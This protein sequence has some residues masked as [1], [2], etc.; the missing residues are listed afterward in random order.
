MGCTISGPIF[1]PM[2]SGLLRWAFPEKNT[3][4]N[5]S[6]RKSDFIN[7]NYIAKILRSLL[8]NLYLANYKRMK[9][10]FLS[11]KIIGRLNKNTYTRALTTEALMGE[12][13]ELKK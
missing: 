1:V 2:V 12:S 3:G 10:F 11:M 9:I 8:L 7:R 13:Q 6:A 4:I 5:R